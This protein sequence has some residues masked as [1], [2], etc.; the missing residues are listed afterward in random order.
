[1]LPGMGFSRVL[2]VALVLAASPVAWP[3]ESPPDIPAIHIAGNG[4]AGGE[5]NL[6]RSDGTVLRRLTGPVRPIW[7]SAILNGGCLVVDRSGQHRAVLVIIEKDIAPRPAR[8]VGGQNDDDS[9]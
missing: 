9:T 4:E 2:A 1:M 3:A 8:E 5:I 6:I 7:L